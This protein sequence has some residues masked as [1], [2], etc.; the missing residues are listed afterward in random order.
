MTKDTRVDWIQKIIVTIGYPKG[1]VLP[2]KSKGNNYLLSTCN[3]LQNRISLLGLHILVLAVITLFKMSFLWVGGWIVIIYLTSFL[4]FQTIW[5]PPHH[6]T[7]SLASGNARSYTELN[8]YCKGGASRPGGS[9]VL[10]ES[11][12][13]TWRMDSRDIQ[14]SRTDYCWSLI[15]SDPAFSI[16]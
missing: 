10:P 9:V 2:Q 1:T 6:S 8:M 14:K 3:P 16:D 7:V 4:I 13:V 11:R 15:F 5:K 12:D